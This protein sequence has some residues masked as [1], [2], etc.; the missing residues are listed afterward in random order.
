MA[1]ERIKL[2]M[3]LEGPNGN[4]FMIMALC[5]RAAWDEGWNA[6]KIKS[7]LDECQSGDHTNLMS[8]VRREFDID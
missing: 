3:D 5:K 7:F 6:E 8:V 1:E 4:V 2:K